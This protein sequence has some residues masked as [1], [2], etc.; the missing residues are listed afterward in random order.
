MRSFRNQKLRASNEDRKKL[1]IQNQLLQ[2]QL[3][4]LQ[5]LQKY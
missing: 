1:T 3:D 5:Q 2:I 4:S